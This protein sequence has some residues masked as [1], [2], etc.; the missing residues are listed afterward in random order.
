MKRS[1]LLEDYI[2]MLENVMRDNPFV[3]P[4]KH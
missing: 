3:H 2:S 1:P 4:Y